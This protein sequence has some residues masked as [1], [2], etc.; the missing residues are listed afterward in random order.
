MFVDKWEP[1]VV[2]SKPELTSAPIWL[3][4]RKVPFQFFNEDGLERI[5]GLVGEPKYLHPMT[6]NKTNLEVAK[7]FTIIDPRK[8]L[9]EAVNV[10]FDSGEICRILV[11]SPWMPPVCEVYREVGHSTKR[12]P[13]VIKTCS[14]CKSK[15]HVLANCPKKPKQ[16]TI[17]R[18]TRRD[19]SKDKQQWRVVEPP[20]TASPPPAQTAAAQP[21]AQ[22]VAA[23]P[24]A[25]L[26]AIQPAAAA[27]VT[28]AEIVK[29]Q[30]ELALTTIVQQSMLG[31]EKDKEIGESS[32]T[33]YY[34][35]SVR[36]RSVSANTRS[37]QSDVQP[38]SS[39]VESSD[40]EQEEGEFSQDDYGF[41]EVHY[42]KKFS[43]LKGNR[44]RGSKNL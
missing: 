17:G 15:T 33:P 27:E 37:S 26:P 39:D 2:P 34:L 4:L 1:G 31:T 21:A 12:C 40:S 35:Q 28:L 6:K 20:E 30:T 13:I 42:K 5:T 41:E 36:Q 25:A 18:K 22:T 38:D 3:E 9:P 23:H 32:N 24:T 10:Q 14:L 44:G 16:E 29:L 43:G 19:M 11:S 7:V 8:P